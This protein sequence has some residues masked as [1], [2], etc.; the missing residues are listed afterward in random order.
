MRPRMETVRLIRPANHFSGS[1][2]T[3]MDKKAEKEFGAAPRAKAKKEVAKPVRWET[4]R[5]RFIP[6]GCE[7]RCYD[8]VTD[9]ERAD[10]AALCVRMAA[11][12]S[13]EAIHCGY[14]PGV[15]ARGNAAATQGPVHGE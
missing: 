8:P 12:Y 1:S 3:G 10:D 14:W 2:T 6:A 7:R 11:D 15:P 13:D 9:W 4:N 5:S